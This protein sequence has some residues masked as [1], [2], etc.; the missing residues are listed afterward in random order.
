[1][2]F[3]QNL[4]RAASK[5]ILR[6]VLAANVSK[7]FARLRFGVDELGLDALVM[8]GIARKMPLLC[9]S[10]Y[11]RTEPEAL[12]DDALQSVSDTDIAEFRSYLRQ[13]LWGAACWMPCVREA[14]ARARFYNLSFEEFLQRVDAV[15]EKFGEVPYLWLADSMTPDEAYG[16]TTGSLGSGGTKQ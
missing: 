5:T 16:A 11:D 9:Q 8:A 4:R 6:E 15:Q 12:T 3:R 14:V 1:M 7:G 13:D 2:V 10:F